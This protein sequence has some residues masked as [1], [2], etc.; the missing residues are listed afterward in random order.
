VCWPAQTINH[1]AKPRSCWTEDGQQVCSGPHAAWTEYKSAGCRTQCDRWNTTTVQECKTNQT[2]GE[3]RVWKGCVGS[4]DAPFNARDDFGGRKFPGLMNVDC[5]QEVLPLTDNRQA[6]LNK[7]N[8][9]WPG[10]STYIP[11]GIMWGARMLTAT[12][13]FTEAAG[14]SSNQSQVHLNRKA[15]IIMTDGMN[16]IQA[17]G[18]WHNDTGN[19]SVPDALTLKACDEAKA[20]GLEVYTVTFGNQVPVAVRDMLDKC[21]SKKDY[22]FHASSNQ[23]LVNAF[24]DIADQLLSIR[25]TQ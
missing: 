22:N 21:A 23:A 3:L 8:G 2:G 13:P 16:T 10:D 7:I 19:S 18:K 6:L 20:N 4:R 17:S 12:Q 25:L 15:L 11:E 14:P 1:P 24:K 9:L 5:A